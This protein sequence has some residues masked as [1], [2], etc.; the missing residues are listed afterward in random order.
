[1]E[2]PPNDTRATERDCDSQSVS[3]GQL[4]VNLKRRWDIINN[5]R[6]EFRSWSIPFLDICVGK[7]LCSSLSLMAA[8][9]LHRVLLAFLVGVVFLVPL[10]TM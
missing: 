6:M 5:F 1:M 7:D 2:R 9:L 4:G 3:H 10:A 8:F